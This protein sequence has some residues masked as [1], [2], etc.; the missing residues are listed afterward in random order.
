MAN[1]PTPQLVCKQCGSSIFEKLEVGQY[2]FKQEWLDLGLPLPKRQ[3]DEWSS[4]GGI[5]YRCFYC[6]TLANKPR[7]IVKKTNSNFR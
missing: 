7:V 5:V 2:Q 4:G 1:E 3:L 6:A